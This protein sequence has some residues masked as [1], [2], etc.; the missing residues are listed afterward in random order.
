MI[1]AVCPYLSMVV[2]RAR[3]GMTLVDNTLNEEYTRVTLPSSC[4]LHHL[5]VVLAQFLVGSLDLNYDR[6]RQRM[7]FQSQASLQK[8][9]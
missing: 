5:P 7:H 1:S 4:S 2:F 9:E 3:W 6:L 8:Q